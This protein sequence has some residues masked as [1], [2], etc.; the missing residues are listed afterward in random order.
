LACRLIGGAGSGTV[1][2]EEA[3]MH[4]AIQLPVFHHVPRWDREA[5]AFAGHWMLVGGN[6][7]HLG[8]QTR[9]L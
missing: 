3:T 9:S 6:P 4:T 1:G 5:K 8:Y 7:F 2:I